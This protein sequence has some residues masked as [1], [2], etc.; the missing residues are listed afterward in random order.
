MRVALVLL[1]LCLVV[2]PS[3]SVD[4][5]NPS[6]CVTDSVLSLVEDYYPLS[7]RITSNTGISVTDT[8][9]TKV[10]FAQ[11]FSV[12][13]YKG[14]K[15]VENRLAKQVYV[16]YSCGTPMPAAAAY[17]AGAKVFQVPLS[18]ISVTDTTALGFV[19]LLGLQDRVMYTTSYSVAPCMQ[20]LTSS[21]CNKTSS[22][23]N[24]A[25]VGGIF[26]GGTTTNT[27]VAVTASADPGALNRAEW[28]KFVSVFFNKEIEANAIFDKITERYNAIKTAATSTPV[29]GRPVIAWVTYSPASIY[30]PA[31]WGFSNATYKEQYSADAGG[32]ALNITALTEQYATTANPYVMFQ[33]GAL[34]FQNETHMSDLKNILSGVDVI[35]DEGY[36]GEGVGGLADLAKFMSTWGLTDADKPNYKF[37]ANNNVLRIDATLGSTNLA[38]AWYEGAVAEP[39]EVLYDM[40]LAYNSSIVPSSEV[41]RTEGKYLRNMATTNRTIVT[42][43]QCALPFSATECKVDYV[44]ICPLLFKNCTG[45]VVAASST[46]RCEEVCTPG[47]SPP[48]PSGADSVT[49]TALS[50][51]LAVL[52]SVVMLALF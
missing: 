12:T 20:K 42:S 28:I 7:T 38:T 47:A 29:S 44:K 13:Y 2:V 26:G 31:N 50:A 33:Y 43:A 39:H 23:D 11:G 35:I 40:V 19:S 22:T 37:L 27:S 3:L 32:V 34:S 17:P 30:G 1:G 49:V 25:L 21:A 52:L 4:Y 41:T 51:L 36:Y 45:S 15:V 8:A 9:F 10:N 48:P 6:E 14:F 46:S 18:S 24:N 5:V 16:L